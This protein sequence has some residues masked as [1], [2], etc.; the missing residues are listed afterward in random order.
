MSLL[1]YSEGGARKL[2]L[3][4]FNNLEAVEANNPTHERGVD[5]LVN[6]SRETA[7][8]CRW[9]QPPF[10]GFVFWCNKPHANAQCHQLKEIT[11][12]LYMQTLFESPER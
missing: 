3:C 6:I 12:V 9:L 8:E 7:T 11:I 2:K 5:N 4:G 1:H 10:H